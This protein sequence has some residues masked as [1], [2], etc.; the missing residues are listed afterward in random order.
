MY[1]AEVDRGIA[2]LTEYFGST[3]WAKTINLET[4]NMTRPS[5]CVLGQVFPEHS[6]WGAAEKVL[7]LSTCSC[8]LPECQG[9]RGSALAYGFT[10]N[11]LG[12][13]KALQER[14]LLKLSELQS[15]RGQA[16]HDR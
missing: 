12:S 11:E 5:Q 10:I 13:W 7:S 15:D 6:Y 14:W 16:A 2:L 8:G 1:E 3:E 4:L 9:D